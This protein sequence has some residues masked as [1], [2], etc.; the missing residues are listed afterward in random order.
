MKKILKVGIVGAG[1]MGRR[2]AF[3][4]IICDKEVRLFDISSEASK[5]AEK[6][7]RHLVEGNFS[8]FSI[9]K[10]NVQSVMS[11]LSINSN[12]KDC[13][14]GVD[15]VIEAVPE[16]IK[17]KQKVFAEI[18][19]NANP[20]TLICTNT[21]SIPG[22][23]LA[24]ATR[25]PEKVFNINFG[26][27]KELKVE[28][29][30]HPLTAKTTFEAAIEFVKSINL[31]PIVVRREILGYATNRVWRAIKHEVLFLLD[32]GYISAEDID[33]GWM[34]EWG[35]AIGP[36]GMMDEVGLDVVRDIEMIYYKAS[37]NPSDKPPKLLLEMIAKGKLGVKSG[38]GFYKYPNPV[39]KN[40]DWLRG[41]SK[42]RLYFSKNMD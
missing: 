31:I 16:N 23:K 40:P 7:V 24:N 26:S 36:C 18:D 2:I 27:L 41:E 20:D 34:L 17:L 21:S 42:D 10:N 22:S 11:F 8:N 4:C 30:P 38:E 37:K 1:T 19:K 35:T 25:R 33:R 9:P 12:L 5:E 32:G 29:M 6:E 28:L 3:G 39:F 14:V 15:L 13:V